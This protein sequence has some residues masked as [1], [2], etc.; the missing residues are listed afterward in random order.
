MGDEDG[1]SL[2]KVVIVSTQSYDHQLGS[3]SQPLS[4]PLSPSG[5]SRPCFR[6]RTT[7]LDKGRD[8]GCDKGPQAETARAKRQEFGQED[9]V[10]KIRKQ[11]D[12]E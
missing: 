7:T 3:L 1:S 2:A 10:R 12:S 11:P 4:Q 8:K 9:G 6:E 5:C